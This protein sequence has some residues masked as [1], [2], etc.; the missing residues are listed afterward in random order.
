MKAFKLTRATVFIFTG[1]LALAMCY[2][3]LWIYLLTGLDEPVAGVNWIIGIFG[4]SNLSWFF[5]PAGIVIDI[6][7][8]PSLILVV[9]A[10]YLVAWVIGSG[11]ELRKQKMD[12]RLR[13]KDGI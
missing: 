8:V 4:Y 10:S 2:F 11:I 7:F 3:G 6:G 9:A 1:L 13:G 12:S 5:A